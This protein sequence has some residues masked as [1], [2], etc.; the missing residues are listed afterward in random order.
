[1]L[2]APT[3]VVDPAILDALRAAPGIVNVVALN[4]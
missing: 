3:S 1:M 2:I 4:S